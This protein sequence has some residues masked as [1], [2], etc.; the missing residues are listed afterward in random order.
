MKIEGQGTAVNLTASVAN[1]A[2]RGNQD[3]TIKTPVSD[4]QKEGNAKPKAQKNL[5][6]IEIAADVLNETMKIYNYHLEFK[7]HKGSGKMQVKVVDSESKKIIREIPPEQILECSARI[8]E[9]LDH[10]A[11]ILVDERI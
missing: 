10:M 2:V 9:L 6:D 4:G 3:K 1:E 5:K 7:L 11:G 8:R